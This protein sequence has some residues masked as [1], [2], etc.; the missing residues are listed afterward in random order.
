VGR[1]ITVDPGKDG[2]NWY[3]YCGDNPVNRI[4]PDGRDYILLNMVWA[5][6]AFGFGHNACLVGNDKDGWVYYS[7]D[8]P[9]GST[10]ERYNSFE[11]FQ[12]NKTADK[13]DR[14][15]RVS[16]TREQDKKMKAYGDKNYKKAYSVWEE[17][18][19][20]ATTN[21]KENCADLAAG[22]GKAGG[23]DISQQ[24]WLKYYYSQHT[25]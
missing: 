25:I 22:V 23:V 9:S 15:Y 19:K 24:E 20:G 8:G 3:A 5:G 6:N 13:Y 2:L 10:R 1:F 7:K 11:E 4:D 14:A 16:T 21:K 18:E 17:K 12:K